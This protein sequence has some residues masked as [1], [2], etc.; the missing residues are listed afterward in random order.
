MRSRLK[1]KKS[2]DQGSKEFFQAH[3]ARTQASHITELADE[4]GATHTS[5]REMGRICQTYYEKLYKTRV[6]SQEAKAAE[7]HALSFLTDKIP[8]AAKERL[9][10]PLTVKELRCAVM[11]MKTGKAPG[12][13]GMTIEF[14]Q[15]YWDLISNDFTTMMRE[16]VQAG[17]LLA[18]SREA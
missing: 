18:E 10:A 6:P 7:K 16:S 14:Y 3:R 12:L 15:C 2:E 4:D 9:R 17:R 11:K 1:W 13:D 5:Q 8:A